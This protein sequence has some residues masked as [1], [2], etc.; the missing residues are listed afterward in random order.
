MHALKCKQLVLNPEIVP[1]STSYDYEQADFTNMFSDN[2]S[3]T[4]N[5]IGAFKDVFSHIKK[6]ASLHLRK[7][8]SILK[9]INSGGKMNLTKLVHQT[10]CLGME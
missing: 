3:V 9:M 6:L 8:N 2:Q 4:K 10:L 7:D 5:S 1:F